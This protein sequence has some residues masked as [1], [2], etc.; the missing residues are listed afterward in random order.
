LAD[1]GRP[2]VLSRATLATAA[3]AVTSLLATACAH[4]NDRSARGT[5]AGRVDVRLEIG[6]PTWGEFG[7]ASLEFPLPRA[8]TGDERRHVRLRMRGPSSD[9]VV[10]ATA[11]V[12]SNGRRLTIVAAMVRRRGSGP[13]RRHSLMLEGT[14]SLADGDDV[15]GGR[16]H[17][18]DGPLFYRHLL[19]PSAGGNG[20]GDAI[21]AP[22]G[23]STSAGWSDRCAV[24]NTPLRRA[25]TPVLL[26]GGGAVKLPAHRLRNG[27]ALVSNSTPAGLV[28]DQTLGKVCKAPFRSRW[29]VALAGWHGAPAP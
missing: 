8:L 3:I 17:L 27:S 20:S 16:G 24:L 4:G 18:V 12:S 14:A 5:A 19:P 11:S 13:V 6:V 28:L 22:A 2:R 25:A 26:S 21:A 10:A 15:R 29:L 23:G 7:L 1:Q 9:K